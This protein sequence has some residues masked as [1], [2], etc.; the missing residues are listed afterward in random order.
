MTLK[1][2]MIA[3]LAFATM[4]SAIP[5][6]TFG[7]I[8]PSSKDYKVEETS[9]QLP[10][11]T[12][13]YQLYQRQ[14]PIALELPKQEPKQTQF[15][16]PEP[17]NFLKAPQ[18][19]QEPDYYQVPI[20][21]QDLVAPVDTEWNPN[22]DP[23]YYYELPAVISKQELPTKEFPK[24]YN[25]DIHDKKKPYS[26]KPKLEVIFE[27]I[28]AKQYEDKQIQLAKNFDQLAK[29]ENQKLIKT[30]QAI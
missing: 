1:L 23:I 12:D 13:S 24:K 19:S 16:V 26:L 29:K 11:E 2:K 21:N 14:L 28:S 25:E 3:V 7:M 17:V 4:S 20:P 10:E 8:S 18:E 5:L 15:Y 6:T 27:P 30:Q 22:G 9:A